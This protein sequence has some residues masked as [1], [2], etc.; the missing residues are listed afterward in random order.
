M[1]GTTASHVEDAGIDDGSQEDR[2][3][4]DQDLEYEPKLPARRRAA[5]SR[6]APTTVHDPVRM[7][8][9][10]VGKTPLLT[11]EGEVELARRI[12]AGLYAA[13]KLATGADGLSPRHY[14]DLRPSSGTVSRQTVSSSKPTSD[15]SSRSRPP[16]LEIRRRPD[17][18]RKVRTST[19]VSGPLH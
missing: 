4:E 15:W 2:G 9:A 5:V 17:R 18:P 19:Q 10:G 3:P 14:Q 7:Y 13:H 6:T 8:L 11:A 1:S 16:H 12:E